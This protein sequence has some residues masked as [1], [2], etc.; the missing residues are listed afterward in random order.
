MARDLAAAGAE[1][2]ELM[3]AG[4]W[5]S[6]QMPARYTRRESAGRSAVARYYGETGPH[7]K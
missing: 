3:Q 7:G 1:L 5:A 4:R 2:P 6:S